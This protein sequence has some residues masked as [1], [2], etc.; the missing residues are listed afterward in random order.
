MER[1]CFAMHASELSTSSS[2]DKGARLQ[3]RSNRSYLAK[4]DTVAHSL[5][6]TS[7]AVQYRLIAKQVRSI[8][9]LFHLW[10]L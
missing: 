9:L 2:S 1:T 10:I 4:R 6:K 3:G 7:I 5:Q 8:P